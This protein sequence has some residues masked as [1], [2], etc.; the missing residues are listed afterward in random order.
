MLGELLGLLLLN[1]LLWLAGAGVLLLTRWSSPQALRCWV[2]LAYLVGAAWTGVVGG[3]LLVAGLAFDR[4]E[5][6]VTAS[7]PILVFAVVDRVRAG[8]R[9]PGVSAAGARWVAAPAVLIAGLMVVRC[10][11]EPMTGWDAFSFWTP[12][13]ESIIYFHGLSAAFYHSGVA[14][15]D[16]PPF[17][18]ALESAAFRFMGQFDTTLVHVQYGLLVLAFVA[19]LAELLR[20]F[21][22]PTRLALVLVLIVVS[23]AVYLQTLS[24]YSDVPLA[25]FV[26]LGAVLLWQGAHDG[27]RA[28]YPLATFA[29]AAALSMKVEGTPYVLAVV[30]AMVCVMRPASGSR[31]APVGVLAVATL[32]SVVPW[33][34]WL[35]ENHVQGTYHP[36]Y[37]SLVDHPGLSLRALDALGANLVSPF[38]WLL[39]PAVVILGL[40]LGWTAGRRQE[41]L[42][43][44]GVVVLAVLA[45]DLTYWLTNYGF[46]WHVATSVN[47]VV[48]TPAL[49]AASFTP[50]LLTP[51]PARD[52]RLG[53]TGE[54]H[55]HRDPELEV[56]AL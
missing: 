3:I 6:A 42:F 35:A 25:I 4:V 52:P 24:A 55:A 28:A 56:F 43:V 33:R 8:A 9:Q 13:A 37:A 44:L 46:A 40:V 10:A 11:F 39:L 45:M 27:I 51:A 20:R 49:L 48:M 15:A 31:W 30:I 23:P 1:A 41:V 38:R 12:K 19:A 21:A 34:V 5:I 36:Q 7:V 22:N 32:V 26:S 47:R 16:Y 54:G 50:L 29:L 17:A 2:G 53:L 14:N 18:T